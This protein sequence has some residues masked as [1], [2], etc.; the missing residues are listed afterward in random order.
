MKFLVN[1]LRSRRAPSTS[2]KAATD[3][4][5][6]TSPSGASTG[7]PVANDDTLGRGMDMALTVLAFLF[8]GWL[9][10]EWL[11]IFPVLTISLVVFAAVG[12]FVRMKYVYD[13][14]MERLETERRAG[15]TRTVTPDRQDAA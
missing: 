9:L 4:P 7:R 6:A 2:P 13:A 8:I 14:A 12:S 3:A 10:D 11:G 1:L 15:S 5:V